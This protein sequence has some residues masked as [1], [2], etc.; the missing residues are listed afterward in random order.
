M[1]KNSKD[2][3]NIDENKIANEN[4]T[5]NTEDEWKLSMQE[6]LKGGCMINWDSPSVWEKRMP[7]IEAKKKSA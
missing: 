2:K 3:T 1:S 6:L 4:K 7:D 5:K